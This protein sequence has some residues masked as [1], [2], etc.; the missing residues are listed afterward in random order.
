MGFGPFT[1][2]CVNVDLANRKGV[3]VVISLASKCNIAS[4]YQQLKKCLAKLG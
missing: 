3:V 2:T 1:C 4:C